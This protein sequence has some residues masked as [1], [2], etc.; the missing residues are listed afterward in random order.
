MSDDIKFGLSDME[1]NDDLNVALNNDEY[2]DQANPAPPAYG[3][4][5]LK[6]LSADGAKQRDSIAPAI[7]RAGEK[8]GQ[9]R[10]KNVGGVAYPVLSIGVVEIVE[11]LGDGITRKL[12]LFADID[13]NPYEREGKEVS[14]L[15]DLARALGLPNYTGIRE[16]LTLLTEAQQTGATFGATLDWESGYDKQFVDAAFEQ[17]GLPRSYK[18]QTPEQAKLANTINRWA[19]VTGQRNFPFNVATGRFSH[20]AQRGNVVITDPNT[21]SKITIEVPTRTLGEASARL[22]VDFRDI[23]FISRERVDSGRVV[24]GPKSVSPV[25][26]AA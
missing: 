8:K 17:L 16:A 15:G 14:Q 6:L 11:G 24:F 21:K 26:A 4:Y 10:F 13:T 22:K 9:Q 3:D 19:K 7:Y 2:Q 23:K 20:I 18:D 25:K 5:L 12:G 1:F